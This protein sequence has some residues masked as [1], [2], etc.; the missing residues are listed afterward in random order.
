MAGAVT[1]AVLVTGDEVLRGRIPDAN[2]G[3]LARDLDARG[4]AVR[5]IVVV[6]DGIDTLVRALRELLDESPDLVVTSGGLGPTHDDRTMEAVAAVTGRPLA[7]DPEA[8]ALVRRGRMALRGAETITDATRARVEDKQATLP[9]G[10]VV[11]PP[12]GTAPGCVVRHGRTLVCV[13][14]GPPWELTR[15]WARACDEVD[16]LRSVLAGAAPGERRLLRLYAVVESEVVE[17]LD[18]LDPAL[19]DAVEAGVCARAGEIELSLRGPAD[20]VRRIEAG[21]EAVFGDRLYARRGETALGLV[22]A[23]LRAR[24]E[25][26]AVAES[27]TGGLLGAR[28]TA[29]PGASE[30]FRG[31]VVAY[32]NSVKEGLL[33][34]DPAVIARHGAVSEECARA[35][36]RGARAAVGADWAVA[37]TGIAGPGGGT[38]DKP[39]GLVHLALAGPGG[40]ED[41]HSPRVLRGD[42]ERIRERAAAIA[43]HL[44]RRALDA[45]P[46]GARHA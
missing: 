14:P 39:V 42:R 23:A 20:A 30:W 8:L 2:G 27:C 1:A 5:R 34:V 35:M 24:G 11:L 6:G 10:A 3:H 43:V 17:T 9:R 28:I 37:V 29:I 21:V 40:V 33:G 46:A 26:L 38:P 22:E 7:V 31:G 19:R 25:T 36:A 18:R 45:A 16:E 44:L 13:L 4:V 41:A 12:T 32:D 15:M